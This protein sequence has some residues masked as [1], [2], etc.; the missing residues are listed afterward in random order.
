MEIPLDVV[1]LT[2]AKDEQTNVNDAMK[3]I[4]CELATCLYL[5]RFEFL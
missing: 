3:I 1:L 5:E 2:F 4:D